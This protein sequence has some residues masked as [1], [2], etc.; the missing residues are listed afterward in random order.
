MTD[1][2]SSDELDERAWYRYLFAYTNYI[3]AKQAS[4]ING[5]EKYLKISFEYSPDPIDKQH[6]PA[7]FYEMGFLFGESEKKESFKPDYLEFLSNTSFDKQKILTL[8]LDIVLR[9]L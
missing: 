8:Y 2:T 5:K 6:Y 4:D 3:K 7:Y 9:D 1:T